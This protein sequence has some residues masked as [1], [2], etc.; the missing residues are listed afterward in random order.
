MLVLKSSECLALRGM[1]FVQ[2]MSK[3]LVSPFSSENIILEMFDLY[4]L[5][6][7]SSIEVDL[8]GCN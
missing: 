1:G 3:T 6:E 7:S 8:G 5:Q 2:G 4:T